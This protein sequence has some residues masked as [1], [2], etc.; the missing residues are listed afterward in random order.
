MPEMR[1]LVGFEVD[2]YRGADWWQDFNVIKDNIDFDFLIGSTHSI[3]NS[4]GTR[5][6]SMYFMNDFSDEAIK[7]YFQNVQACIASKAFNFIAHIDLICKFVPTYLSKFTDIMDET[8]KMLVEYKMLTEINT[9]GLTPK[10]KNAFPEQSILVKLAT[11]NVPMF[12]SDDAHSIQR[13]G[14]NFDIASNMLKNA[15]IVKCTVQDILNIRTR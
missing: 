15:G 4:N 10:S 14:A 13:V 3:S 9:S 1:T 11:N 6:R 2:F 8:I 7:N 12:I 5:C